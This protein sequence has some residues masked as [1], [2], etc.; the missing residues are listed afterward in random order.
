MTSGPSVFLDDDPT[1]EEARGPDAPATLNFVDDVPFP[2]PAPPTEEPDRT[3]PGLGI[4][5]TALFVLVLGAAVYLA[6]ASRTDDVEPL[7]S[8]ASTAA[9]VTEAEGENPD[10]DQAATGQ[11]D[12]S[13][14]P[15]GEG[16]DEPA[17]S[18]PALG[19]A[20]SPDPSPT[21]AGPD[22][23]SDGSPTTAPSP[24]TTIGGSTAAPSTAPP[25]TTAPSTTSTTVRPTTT[26]P[27]SAP[28]T[29]RNT[30]GP[31]QLVNPG[32]LRSRVGEPVSENFVAV[33][34][35]SAP[36]TFI[37]QGLPDGLSI[38]AATGSVTGT[39]RRAGVYTVFASIENGSAS[40]GQG[41]T[42]VV[43][44]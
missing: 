20:A 25:S 21:T 33:G 3:T 26:P 28:P 17:S 29:S 7:T 9:A 43:D 41:F 1:A 31:L 32:S 16:D 42:W 36:V 10:R 2:A 22:A 6:F 5:A 37:A 35:G 15:E 4:G 24:S 18:L 30:E 8:P 27:T 14:P 19:D 23:D 11:D 38:D 34:G 40:M 13:D 39:P 44:E 12:R